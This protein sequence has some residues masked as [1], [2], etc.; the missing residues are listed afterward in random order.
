MQS[1]ARWSPQNRSALTR[2]PRGS[3]AAKGFLRATKFD[4]ARNRVAI[5]GTA[6]QIT[7]AVKE[8]K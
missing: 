8:K 2:A 6:L 5:S 7:I 1:D 4:A 3:P